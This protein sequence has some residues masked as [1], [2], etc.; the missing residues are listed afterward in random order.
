MQIF[1][2]LALTIK[3]LLDLIGMFN[4]TIDMLDEGLSIVET[5]VYS[6]SAKHMAANTKTLSADAKKIMLERAKLRAA[7]REAS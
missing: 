2:L 3:S 7:K 4:R 6:S 5:E 1:T